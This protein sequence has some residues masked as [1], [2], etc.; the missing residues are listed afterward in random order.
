MT[1]RGKISRSSV[2]Q[3]PS[4]PVEEAK[5]ESTLKRRR[6]EPPDWPHLFE[7]LLR[8]APITTVAAMLATAMT[9]AAQQVEKECAG[10]VDRESD[11]VFRLEDWL[12][13]WQFAPSPYYHDPLLDGLHK[14]ARWASK[15][16]GDCV[17]MIAKHGAG[18]T[19]ALWFLSLAIDQWQSDSEDA[20][21]DDHQS[22]WL[23][24]AVRCG[25]DPVAGIFLALFEQF[26]ERGGFQTM[27]VPG[28]L[29]DAGVRIGAGNNDPFVA[30]VPLT[31]TMAKLASGS[32]DLSAA[33][34]PGIEWTDAAANFRIARMHGLLSLT[35]YTLTYL[36]HTRFDRYRHGPSAGSATW[37]FE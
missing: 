6:S 11:M 24:A 15:A 20:G 8:E 27:P 22:R 18:P 5:P 12:A 28:A 1:K 25:R 9:E 14:M 13:A 23:M 17:R 35:G 16:V 31:M 4:S 30:I 2:Q 36:G 21:I 26:R 19:A 7:K 10:W 29:T 34:G 3:D 37:A 33:L 32:H